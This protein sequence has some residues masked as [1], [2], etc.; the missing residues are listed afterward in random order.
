M[1]FYLSPTI[2][3]TVCQMEVN[4]L[5]AEAQYGKGEETRLPE[6]LLKSTPMRR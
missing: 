4:R 3:E 5:L 6:D 2:G 1:Q